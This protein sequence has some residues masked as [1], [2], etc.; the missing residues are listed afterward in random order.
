ML[1][2][3]FDQSSIDTFLNL[4][5]LADRSGLAKVFLP[6]EFFDASKNRMLRIIR[7]RIRVARSRLY[8]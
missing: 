2:N 7:Q 1:G 5:S 8:E 4:H 6:Q 3:Y